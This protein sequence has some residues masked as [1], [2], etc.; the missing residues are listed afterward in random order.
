MLTINELRATYT[1]YNQAYFDGELP[2]VDRVTIEYSN[3]LSSS[4][5]L[6]YPSRRVI[7]ISSHYAE[8]YGERETKSVL[9]HEM[10]HL[11]IRGHGEKFHAKMHDI[12]SRGGEVSRYS[13]GRAKVNWEYV[14][15]E[16]QT[17]YQRGV[18]L[19]RGGR[20]HVCGRCKGKL[21][22]WRVT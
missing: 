11:Q 1:E 21:R 22:E 14:C 17:K 7:R 9:L 5:G 18:R 20:N 19:G 4:A 15:V 3:R 12:Q 6:C 10:I 8:R 2:P 16:C 13:K